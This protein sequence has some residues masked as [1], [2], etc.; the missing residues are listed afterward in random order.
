MSYILLVGLVMYRH[1]ENG[2]K[3]SYMYLHTIELYRDFE[4]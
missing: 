1:T 4:T 2:S 3:L